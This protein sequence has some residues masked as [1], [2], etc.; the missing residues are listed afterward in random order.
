[1][2][3]WLEDLPSWDEEPVFTSSMKYHRSS[4]SIL[5]NISKRN[6]HKLSSWKKAAEL[7]LEPC[8]VCRPYFEARDDESYDAAES[9]PVQQ[10]PTPTDSLET[11]RHQL[12]A[13]LNAW[14]HELMQLLNNLD[15]NKPPQESVWG[16]IVRLSR[17]NTIPRH[18]EVLMLVITEMRNKAEYEANIFTQ[19]EIMAVFAAHKAVSEW[20]EAQGLI[21]S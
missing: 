13:Q 3:E 9:L 1:M 16:R 20:A 8:L 7:G 19:W 2:T 6:F 4:C 5:R 14:R 18:I 12:P 17:S 15:P 10:P 11:L 21:G